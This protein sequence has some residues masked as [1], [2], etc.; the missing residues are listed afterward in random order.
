MSE[1]HPKNA[2][3]HSRLFPTTSYLP[4]T[5]KVYWLSKP[6]CSFDED[7]NVL[8]WGKE[9]NRGS[10]VPQIWFSPEVWMMLRL[11]GVSR[12]FL[13]SATDLAMKLQMYSKII[14]SRSCAKQPSR[15]FSAKRWRIGCGHNLTGCNR[16]AGLCWPF[17]AKAYR[18]YSSLFLS[19]V[20]LHI[21]TVGTKSYIAVLVVYTKFLIWV[22]RENTKESWVRLKVLRWCRKSLSLR[23]RS[24]QWSYRR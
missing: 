14:H 12:Y 7:N 22:L 8:S 3:V 10:T 24:L 5:G 6:L 20:Y 23:H 18:L 19:Y 9:N 11:E 4:F 17:I 16:A 15:P 1:A 13:N 21:P 2:S